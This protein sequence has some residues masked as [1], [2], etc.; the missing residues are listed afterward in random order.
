M[1][2]I[3]IEIEFQKLDTMEYKVKKVESKKVY[4]LLPTKLSDGKWCWFS[5]YFKH[6]EKRS[7]LITGVCRGSHFWGIINGDKDY[8]ALA[9]KFK[10]DKYR[11]MLDMRLKRERN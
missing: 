8:W 10:T 5:N 1:N 4:A 11:I 7:P 9:S 2:K 3:E 6:Y